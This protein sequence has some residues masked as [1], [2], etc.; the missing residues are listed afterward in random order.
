MNNE[1]IISLIRKKLR[2]QAPN[3]PKEKI[4]RKLNILNPDIKEYKTYGIKVKDIE[5]IVKE[6][7]KQVDI[8]YNDVIKIFIELTKS[9]IEEEK[10]AGFMLLNLYKRH[11]NKNLLKTI[12]NLYSD[13]CHTWS[14]CDSTSIRVIGPF[15]AKNNNS[16]LAYET[17][18]RWIV[19]ENLWI[20]RMSLAS[21]VKIIMVKK[22]FNQKFVF[23]LIQKALEYE[24]EYYIKKAVAWVLRTCSKYQ[25]EIIYKY[26]LE[27]KENFSRLIL[28]EGSEKLEK[29][30]RS[31]ILDI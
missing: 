12:E 24:K 17:L 28:R 3:F 18:N 23:E 27:N 31:T 8:S 14:H 25:P 21:L 16:Q 30:K 9:T 10:F 2:N 29:L 26:L 19:H 6:V 22:K 1:Q 13:H 11:F 4:E 5:T 7:D 20:R 15:L